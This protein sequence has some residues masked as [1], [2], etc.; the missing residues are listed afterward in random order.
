MKAAGEG[1]GKVAEKALPH[2]AQASAELLGCPGRLLNSP[3]R[4]QGAALG[5][6]SESGIRSF[7]EVSWV[8]WEAGGR[9]AESSPL[10]APVSL[11]R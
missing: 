10:W 3:F 11:P 7:L 9:E 4:D 5:E 1:A 2:A 8:S 6:G